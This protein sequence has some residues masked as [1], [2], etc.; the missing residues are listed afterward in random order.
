MKVISIGWLAALGSV[1]AA[2]IFISQNFNTATIPVATASS[3][4]RCKDVVLATNYSAKRLDCTEPLTAL[5]YS[6]W[7]R[8]EFKLDINENCYIGYEDFGNFIFEPKTTTCP[9]PLG[10]FN[11]MSTTY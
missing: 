2:T 5:C 11:Y 1:N 4:K 10:T 6:D 7:W 9:L 8:Y 3:Y